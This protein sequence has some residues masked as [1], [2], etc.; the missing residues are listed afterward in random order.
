M[1]DLK[2]KQTN[3][4]SLSESSFD[5]IN[6]KSKESDKNLTHQKEKNAK[7]FL[8]VMLCIV[9]AFVGVVC[10]FIS[11][12]NETILAEKKIN[13]LEAEANA[14]PTV[15]QGSS[16]KSE[17]NQSQNN[18][19]TTAADTTAKQEEPKV[20]APPPGTFDNPS[21]IKIDK[22]NWEMTLVNSAYRIPDSYEPDLIFVCD[23]DQR[24]DRKVAAA[25]EKMYEAGLK[26]GVTLTPC[27]GYRSY[28]RQ[29]NNY[30]RKI[31][32]YLSQGFSEK[33]A[34]VKAATIIMPPGSS[35]HNLGYAM[36][37]VVVEEWFDSTAEFKWLMKNA[38]NYG[39]ILRYPKDKQDITKVIYEPWHWRYVG[40]EN[41]KKIKASGLCLEEYLGVAK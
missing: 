9:V 35:E 15:T 19:D 16:Q 38:Q 29:K 6:S 39:F 2:K 13:Q 25:Y 32:Y 24:L 40:V 12:R 34:K 23:S 14:T 7:K 31:N 21:T 22:D 33:E 28:E 8:L 30:T 3:D 4:F 18:G 41:A 27:S 1:I 36:D 11:K 5:E 37:I 26:D 10:I 20:T 17:D